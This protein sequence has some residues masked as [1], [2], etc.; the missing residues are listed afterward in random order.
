MEKGQLCSGARGKPQS[1]RAPQKNRLLV[2]VFESVSKIFM[3]ALPQEPR[4]SFFL[5]FL[6]GKYPT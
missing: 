3:D 5:S 2:P 1:R 4:V 6:G